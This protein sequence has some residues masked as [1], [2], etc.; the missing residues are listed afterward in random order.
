MDDIAAEFID[1]ACGKEHF[2]A[3]TKEGAVY[4]WGAGRYLNS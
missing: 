1:I 3:L 4:T 2:M